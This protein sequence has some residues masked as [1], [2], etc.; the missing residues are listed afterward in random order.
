MNKYAALILLLPVGLIYAQDLPTQHKVQPKDTLW[1]LAQRYYGDPFKWP[2]IAQAN[3]PPTVNDPHWIYPQ[4]VLQIPALDASPTPVQN[5]RPP[6]PTPA[7]EE[8]EEPAALPTQ[9]SVPAT[10]EPPKPEP[11]TIAPKKIKARTGLPE[12]GL[13]NEFPDGLVG[14][15]P[16]FSRFKAA[17]GWH[18]DGAI[19][20]SKMDGERA[21]S[22]GDSVN[23]RIDATGD[24]HPGDQYVILRKSAPTDADDDQHAAYLADIGLLEI[25]RYVSDNIYRAMILRSN[26]SIQVD[27]MIKRRK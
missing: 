4:Q 15:T 16:S 23:V 19:R 14:Q 3:P 6:A 7:V 26:D 12:D 8:P 18:A 17:P 25:Q 11:P 24:I 1:D 9:A 10:P 20:E 5:V 22:Q 2:N 13:S 21:L 27:D